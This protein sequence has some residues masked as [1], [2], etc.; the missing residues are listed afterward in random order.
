MLELIEI[1]PAVEVQEAEYRRLLGYPAD[2][3]VTGRSAELAEWARAWYREHGRPWWYVRQV[4]RLATGDGVVTIDGTTFRSLRLSRMMAD[5][6][7]DS[8]ALLAVTAGP[9]CE[10]EARRL[11]EDGKPDEFFFLEVYGSAVVEALV[12]AASYG[13][14]EWADQRGVAVLPHYSPGYPDWDIVDQRK[15]LDLLEGGRRRSWPGGI[16]TLET[17]MLVPK[18]S[19][20]G[21]F[22][23]TR[24]VAA[25]RPLASLAPCETCALPRCAYRRAPRRRPLPSAERVRRPAPPS[26]GGA[27]ARVPPLSANGR[28]SVSAAVLRRWARERLRV[29]VLAGGAVEARFRYDGTTCSN[30]GRPLAF[31]YQVRLTSPEEGYRIVAA[32]CA[33][34]P[35]DVGHRSMCRYLEGSE[36]LMGEIVG[37]HPLLGRPLE[38]VLGWRRAPSPA[39]CYCTAESRAHKWGL[40]LEVLHFALSRDGSTTEAP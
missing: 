9:E 28:Y 6:R 18:K 37:E 24:H 16:A 30:L 26:G 4:E 23:I 38:D 20:L 22:G 14:C 36:A 7:A 10:R 5:A 35:D 2:H 31:D 32:H 27:P 21:L 34:A 1:G 15:L 17:G 12:A 11:W 25:V 19:L 3:E 33:P 29:A 13:L 8:G 39:G 40:V